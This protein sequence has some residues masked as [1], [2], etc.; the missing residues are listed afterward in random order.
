MTWW[1]MGP[2]VVGIFVILAGAL[3]GTLKAIWCWQERRDGKR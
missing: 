1:Q 3:V 2:L